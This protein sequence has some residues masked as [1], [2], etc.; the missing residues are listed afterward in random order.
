MRCSV[1]MICVALMVAAPDTLDFAG[2]GGV[3]DVPSCRV[4]VL[5]T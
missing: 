2:P 5:E 4:E 1:V 3:G